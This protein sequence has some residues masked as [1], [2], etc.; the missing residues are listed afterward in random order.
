MRWY[1]I[2]VRKYKFFVSFCSILLILTVT[3]SISVS[4]VD[5]VF[6]KE[7]FLN[8]NTDINNERIIII[9]AGHGGEDSG[10]VGANGVLEKALALQIAFEVGRIFSEKGYA[11]VYTRTEDKLLYEPEENIKGIRKISDLK[12]RCKIAELYPEA[13]FV[14]I[15][16]NSFGDKKYSGMQVYYS[17][18]SEQSRIIADSVQNRVRSDLQDTNNRTIKQG[19]DIYVLENIQNPAILIECGFLSNEEE[20]KKLSEKEYQKKLSFSIVC[21]IIEVIE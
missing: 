3:L 2:N 10:T 15:H 5:K 13:L 19:K 17:D 9:D 16:L 18:N 21:G 1:I 12:N 14:S 7:L 8:A 6:G 20:C 4:T 11:V